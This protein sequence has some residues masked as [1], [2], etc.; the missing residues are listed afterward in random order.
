[1]LM[2]KQKDQGKRIHPTRALVIGFLVI[3]F[4]GG[5]LLSLPI[6]SR[7]QEWTSLLTTLFTATSATCVT[8]LVLVDTY[9]YWSPFGQLVILML[10]QIGGLGFMSM[11]T[12]LSFM[13]RRTITL[14]ERMVLT[15]SLNVADMSGIVR[16]TRRLLFGTLLFEGIG[17]TIL[18]VRFMADYAPLDA[19][20]KG[21]FHSISAFCNAGFDLMGQAA[22]FSSMVH[23]ATDPVINITLMLL[24]IV[25]GLGFYVWNDIYERK[26]LSHLRLHTKIVLSTSAILMLVS[27]VLFALFEWHNPFTLGSLPLRSRPLAAFFQ[28]VTLRTAG[29]N[30]IDQGALTGA[31]KA[32]SVLMMFIGGSPGSTAGGIK[33]VTVAVLTLAA[34]TAMRGRTNVFVF[35]RRIVPRS[36]MNAVTMLM[37]GFTLATTG[38]VILSVCEE[39]SFTACLFEAVSA[40]GTVGISMGM[41][42]SIGAVSKITLMLLMFLG[43]VGI[44]TLG[45]AVLMGRQHE[46]KMQ[47][48]D[49][50]LFVG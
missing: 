31:S 8:G 42:P 7:Q 3:I 5:V 29:F 30:T 39:Q 17:A 37:I 23:Y 50:Q 11:A 4:I 33:T 47:Y 43:R 40:F 2:L 24:V 15:T 22:P 19:I 21:V 34:V 32:I 1:M 9:T 14:R 48:P 20:S 18:S 12:M 28:A 45:V 16:M 25:G 27:A 13:L 41:T 44:L 6:S 10:I 38:A 26:S 35:G 46:P 49:E 36:I